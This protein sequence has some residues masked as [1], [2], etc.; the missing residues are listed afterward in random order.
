MWFSWAV[1]RG[2]TT[3]KVSCSWCFKNS[4]FDASIKVPH[5]LPLKMS[6]SQKRKHCKSSKCLFRRNYAFTRRFDSYTFTKKPWLHFG[7]RF[8]LRD[9]SVSVIDVN[10]HI[11]FWAC[12]FPVN[13]LHT[14]TA[15]DSLWQWASAF[16]PLETV[17]HKTNEKTRN[18]DEY[19]AWVCRKF[20]WVR[21]LK[22]NE[23]KYKV[24]LNLRYLHCWGLNY[25]YCVLESRWAVQR[26]RGSLSLC[27]GA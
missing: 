27:R 10:M 13:P 23:K 1:C 12:F 20:P 3:C 14:P 26:C 25:G 17:W 16:L 22:P 24:W 21:E 18:S 5:A 4:N 6:L 15:L 11:S 7:E 2:D 8:T 19:L 9:W